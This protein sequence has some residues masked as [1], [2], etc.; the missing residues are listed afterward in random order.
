MEAINDFISQINGVLWGWPMII[1]LLGTHIYLTVILRFPQRKIFKAIKLSVSKDQGAE[2]DVSQFGALATALAATIGTGNIV[3]VGTAI[4]LGGPGAVFWCWLTGVFG[5]STKYAEGLLAIKYRVKTTDGKMLGGPMYAL[6]RGLGWKWLGVLF[7]I[8]CALA[9]FGKGIVDGEANAKHFAVEAAEFY[10]FVRVSGK[11]IEAYHDALPEAFEI[12]DVL[13][14]V[15]QAF[16]QASLIGFLDMGFGHTA[17]QLEALG[18]SHEHCQRRLKAVLATLDVEELLSPEVCTETGFRDDVIAEGQGQT[19]GECTVA[20]MCNVG[21]GSAVY[22]G[23][24]LLGGLNEVGVESILQEDT[25][26]TRHAHILHAEG[27][28]VNGRA[29]QD[30][31][32][33]SAQVA[34]VLGEAKYCHNLACRGD[35]E[36]TL[37]CYA[38]CLGSEASDDVAKVAV[39]NVEDALPEHLFHGEAF[40][41]VLIDVVVEQGSYHVVGAGHGVEVAGEVEVYLIHREH[42]R[43]AS[44]CRAAFHAETGTERR[45]TERN[46]GVFADAVHAESKPDAHG[47]LA[48]ARLCGRDGCDEDELVLPHLLF[49]NER[50]GDFC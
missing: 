30:I 46:D 33:A 38:V 36:A 16:A 24:R 20:A 27:F 21:E 13:V 40:L 44:S 9:S 31:L 35:V 1:L 29:E 50:L 5:I 28:A 42:L 8:F 7:A 45:L 14:E 3:G 12:V 41:A 48:D 34:T 43:I 39:I 15:L 6:E 49:I 23:R 4:A 25:D 47:C 19:R 32:D 26:G 37:H 22:E 2:G 11:T 10:L 18:G 17:M